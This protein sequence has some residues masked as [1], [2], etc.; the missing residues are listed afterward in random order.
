MRCAGAQPG[1]IAFAGG[2]EPKNALC[3]NGFGRDRPVLGHN[4]RPSIVQNF[5]QD[6]DRLRIE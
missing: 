3:E 4:C 5:S 6:R 2:R 1:R